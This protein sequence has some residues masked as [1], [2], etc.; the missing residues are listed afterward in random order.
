M[1][2]HSIEVSS[3]TA[4][5]RALL[6]IGYSNGVKGPHFFCYLFDATEPMS[7]PL[8]NSMFS[9]EHMLVQNV[10]EFDPILSQW[11]VTL[12]AFLKSALREDWAKNIER[13]SEYCWQEDGTFEQV[14]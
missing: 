1:S 8:W 11:G 14:A 13:V 3:G 9:L 7:T 10:D 4:A 6:V 12:P 5:G 2:R